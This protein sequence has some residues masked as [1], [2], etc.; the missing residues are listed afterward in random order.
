M[1]RM[2]RECWLSILFFSASAII[3][4][5]FVANGPFDIGGKI[6]LTSAPLF[7]AFLFLIGGRST[8][9]WLVFVC[10]LFGPMMVFARGYLLPFRLLV[11]ITVPTLWALGYENARK[12]L[13]L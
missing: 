10:V 12:C 7:L 5:I 11:I 6:F 4:G 8:L 2:K 3:W 1:V 13:R 9:S